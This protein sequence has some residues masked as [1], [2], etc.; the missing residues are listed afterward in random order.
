MSKTNRAPFSL[1]RPTRPRRPGSLAWAL[2][3][4]AA[5]VAAQDAELRRCRAIADATARLAC[6]DAL[7]LAAP[8]ARAGAPATPPA[9]PTAAA[10]AAG[11]VAPPAAPAAPR[12]AAPPSRV[13]EAAFGLPRA[14]SPDNPDAIDSRI[15]G[16]FDGWEPNTKF[17]LANGQL[18]QIADGSRAHLDLKDP[19]VRIRK[20]G[21]SSALYMEI[22]GQSLL[23]RVRRLE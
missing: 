17:R 18:W 6:Y 12:G 8:A 4:A 1:G 15:P 14:P 16:V 5:P 3:F 2:V 7:P 20:S 9:A 22:E 11:S 13:G 21:V 23:P 19:R 10:A